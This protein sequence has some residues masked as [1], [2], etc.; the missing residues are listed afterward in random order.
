MSVCWVLTGPSKEKCAKWRR[1]N[2]SLVFNSNHSLHAATDYDVFDSHTRRWAISSRSTEP[3]Y[4]QFQWCSAHHRHEA[5]GEMSNIVDWGLTNKRI[6]KVIFFDIFSCFM[7]E[8]KAS[9]ESSVSAHHESKTA[10]Q[11]GEKSRWKSN[12]T[13][14]KPYTRW[15]KM[16]NNLTNVNK[17]QGIVLIMSA[18]ISA[19]HSSPVY[20]AILFSSLSQCTFFFSYE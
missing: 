8:S 3:L 4:S 5:R 2:F 18:H 16:E 12:K 9:L 13:I 14:K 6:W 7:R 19:L 17:L 20:I 1:H 15:I 11:R 10:Q